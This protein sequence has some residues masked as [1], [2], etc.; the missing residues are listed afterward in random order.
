MWFIVTFFLLININFINRNIFFNKPYSQEEIILSK[1]ELLIDSDFIKEE[2]S[3]LERKGRSSVV[4]KEEVQKEVDKIAKDMGI[5]EE[6]RNILWDWL[7]EWLKS[8]IPSNDPGP[9]I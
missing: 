9:Q 8:K 7:W 3:K 6:Q 4:S 1:K 5:D 2:I